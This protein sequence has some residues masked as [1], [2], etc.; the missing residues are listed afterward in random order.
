MNGWPLLCIVIGFL[1][2]GGVCLMIGIGIGHGESRMIR[3]AEQAREARLTRHD[4]DTQLYPMFPTEPGPPGRG[5][6]HL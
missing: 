2:F 5:P 1:M 6:W 4:D 3:E